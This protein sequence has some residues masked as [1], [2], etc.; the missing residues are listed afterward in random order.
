MMP[1][2]DADGL[3]AP[4]HVV[5]AVQVTAE[6]D[7]RSRRNENVAVLRW[8]TIAKHIVENRTSQIDTAKASAQRLH[9]RMIA[10]FIKQHSADFLSETCVKIGADARFKGVGLVG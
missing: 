9:E 6:A 5:S 10:L 2:V 8:A 4:H 7:T 3:T 1:E